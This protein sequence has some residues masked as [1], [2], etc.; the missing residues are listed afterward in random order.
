MKTPATR[1]DPFAACPVHAPYVEAREIDGKVQVRLQPP[2]SAGRGGWRA[3][4][5]RRLTMFPFRLVCLDELGT[6]YWK[7]VDGRRTLAEIERRLRDHARLEPG[8]S[9]DAVVVFTKMLM[10]RSLIA[11]KLPGH[12][13]AARAGVRS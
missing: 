6:F 1:K 4:L 11:L 12:A 10:R 8:Q 2:P 5:A 13:E 3:S 9:R 7:Q